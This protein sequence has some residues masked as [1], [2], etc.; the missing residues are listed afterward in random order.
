MKLYFVRHGESTANIQGEFS[1]RNDKHP[2]TAK[3][4]EQARALAATLTGLGVRRIHTS[5][6]LRARQ[7]ALLLAEQLQVEVQ[8]EEALRE[9][10]VGIHEGSTDPEG[11]RLHREVQ[12]DWFV[13]NK[14]DSKMPGGESFCEI[15]ARFV[16]LLES[17]T[18]D[19][20]GGDRVLVA[21]GGLYLAMLPVVLKN[22]SFALAQQYGFP[23]TA[24]VT[25]ETRPAGLWCI[26]WNGRPIK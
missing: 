19:A 7:T 2:L 23:H 11:W 13:H 14:L 9:W 25:A 24:C 20:H 17:L 18:Q 1:N 22:V 12:E 4:V 26:S 8:S 6:V 16:P 5:P 3:G 21:H 10:D 15:R